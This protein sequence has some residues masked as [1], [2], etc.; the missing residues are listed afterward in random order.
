[1]ESQTAIAVPAGTNY[2]QVRIKREPEP[3]FF[4]IDE[5]RSTSAGLVGSVVDNRGE[6]LKPNEKLS[7]DQIV[8]VT[9][10]I[11]GDGLFPRLIPVKPI[12]P[13]GGKR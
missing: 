1:M 3:F 2:V 5:G 10:A 7:R 11:M 8:A 6:C 9:R 12:M 13:A 4:A